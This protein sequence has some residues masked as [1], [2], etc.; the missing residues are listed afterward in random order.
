MKK[1]YEKPSVMVV[2]LQQ[3]ACLLQASEPADA[4]EYDDYL[5]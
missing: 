3:R 5:G 2:K 4:K 1:K